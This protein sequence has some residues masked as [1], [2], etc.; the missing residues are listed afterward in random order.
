MSD[1]QSIIQ[2]IPSPMKS[3][4]FRAFGSKGIIRNTPPQSIPDGGVYDAQNYISTETGLRRRPGLGKF[5]TQAAIADDQN[6]QDIINF[7]SVTGAQQLLLL[8]SRLPLPSRRHQWL[9]QNL[10]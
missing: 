10:R 4:A 2:G 9:H 5:T 8:W 3:V 1:Y 7:W 6:I